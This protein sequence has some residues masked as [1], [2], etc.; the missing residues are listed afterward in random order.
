M[1]YGLL[2][3]TEGKE[4]YARLFREI[5]KDKYLGFGDLIP[6]SK[7]FCCDVNGVVSEIEWAALYELGH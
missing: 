5:A 4:F 2:I 3:P 1:R 6:V 7:I